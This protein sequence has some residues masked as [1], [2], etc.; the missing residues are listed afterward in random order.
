[1]PQNINLT[2]IAYPATAPRLASR[3]LIIRAGQSRKRDVRRQQDDFRN[4][5][6]GLE[7]AGGQRTLGR[8]G[9]HGVSAVSKTTLAVLKANLLMS[10]ELFHDAREILTEAI[11][12]D[13]DEPTLHFVLGELYDKIGLK[14]LATEEYNEAE[15]LAKAKQ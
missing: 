14:N 1:M 15:F 7:V 2:K 13:T 12:A 6:A 11:G 3:M 9:G 10:K 4:C 8:T 5:L